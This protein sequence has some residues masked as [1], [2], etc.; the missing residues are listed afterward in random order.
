MQFLKTISI[1]H[2]PR[3]TSEP[4]QS[5]H[6]K[7]ALSTPVLELSL[8]IYTSFFLNS[9]LLLQTSP[10]PPSLTERMQFCYKT[11]RNWHSLPGLKSIATRDALRQPRKAPAHHQLPQ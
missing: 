9:I 7:T 2:S 1:S 10:L 5:G 4:S 8:R 3:R 11:I 6:P